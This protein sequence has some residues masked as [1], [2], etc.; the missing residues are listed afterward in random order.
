MKS[1]EAVLL[2]GGA[3]SRMGLD[4]ASIEV[5]GQPLGARIA[6]ELA[7]RAAKVTILGREPIEP[8]AFQIDEDPLQGPLAA[9]GR[10]KPSHEFVFVASC[11]LPRFRAEVVDD[12]AALIGDLDAAIPVLLGRAQPLCA[13]YRA[14]AF[15][16]ARKLSREGERRVMAWIRGLEVVEAS[17]FPSLEACANVN[18]PE[19]LNQLRSCE[20]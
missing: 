9:L 13:L 6:A 2:T 1:V 20:M 15:T 11:D 17:A 5:D 4:K 16:S 14:R 12:L 3:S 7:K 8:Y 10:F 18:T 19:E